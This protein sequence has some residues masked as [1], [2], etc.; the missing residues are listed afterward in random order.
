MALVTSNLEEMVCPT[1][2]TNQY[3]CTGLQS[4]SDAS[5][6]THYSTLKKRTTST[7][8]KLTLVATIPVYRYQENHD[9]M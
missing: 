1:V 6:F 3:L 9:Q 7:E 4:Q 5:R 2:R 8:P